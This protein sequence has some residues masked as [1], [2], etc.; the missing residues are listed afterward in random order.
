MGADADDEVDGEIALAVSPRN[1]P[2][3]GI[4]TEPGMVLLAELAL[5]HEMCHFAAP[6]HDAAFVKHLLRAL[7]KVSWEPLV[8]KCMPCEIPG[9]DE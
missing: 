6:N 3:T 5:L 1:R 9:L 2:G 8:G 4:G 7:Q